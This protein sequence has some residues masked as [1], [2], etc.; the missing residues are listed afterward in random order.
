[1]YFS[2]ITILAKGNNIAKNPNVCFNFFHQP[3]ERQIRL[4]GTIEKISDI[5]SDDYYNSRPLG[6]R[7]G[8][9]ASNQSEKL[10]SREVLEEK[11]K[12]LENKFADGNV[13]RPKHWGGYICKP[14]YFEF[15]QG[16]GSRL[17]DRIAYELINN[18]WHISRLSP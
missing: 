18:T 17:H 9:W 7:L 15:W 2:L 10:N 6:N 14:N 13:P 4:E 12:E 11:Q 8:A 5:D 1:M 16:R 3:L